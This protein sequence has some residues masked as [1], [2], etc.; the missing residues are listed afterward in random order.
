[1]EQV[2]PNSAHSLSNLKGIALSYF[3]NSLIEPDLLH[4][5]AWGD[6]Y[7]EFTSELKTY[8]GSSDVVGEA[9]TCGEWAITLHGKLL[10]PFVLIL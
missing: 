6:N 7:R 4:L 2:Q 8:F 1:M 10:V 9:E 5:L 3:E